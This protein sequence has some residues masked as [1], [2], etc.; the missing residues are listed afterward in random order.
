M[1]RAY[2]SDAVIDGEGKPVVGAAVALLRANDF[3][4][5]PTSDP[6]S[7]FYVATTY[8]GAGGEFSF[9]HLLPDD[10]HVMVTDQGVTAFRYFV[11]AFA[12]EMVPS[13]SRGG[14]NLIPRTLSRLLAGEDVVIQA[15]G[16]G[17]T[18]GYDSTGTVAGSWVH[19]LGVLIG[20]ELAPTAE[21]VRYDPGAYGTLTDGPIAA[22]SSPAVIQSGSGGQT[23]QIVNSSV[24]N[25]TVQRV[26]RRAAANLLEP[27]VAP[28]D[29]CLI[30]L[31]LDDSWT[32]DGQRFVDP[33][34]FCRG[35]RALVDLLKA[36]YSQAEIAL[37]TPAC[38]N[39]PAAGNGGSIVAG[40]YTLEQYAMGVRRVAVD[41]GCALVDVSQMFADRFDPSDP[42][43]ATND[44]YGD[45]L[46]AGSHIYPTDA[47]H[48]AMAE[49]VFKLF[50]WPGLAAGRPMRIQSGATVP[51]HRTAEICRVPSTSPAIGYGGGHWSSYA[52]GVLAGL[53]VSGGSL[54]RS[55]IAGD[56]LT[57]KERMTDVALLTR[58][59]ADCGMVSVAIDGGAPV[60]VD[61][62]RPLPSDI[63][64]TTA[65]GAVY[66]GEL[67]WLARG[68]TDAVH[69][70][71][72]TVLGTHDVAA[73]DSYVYVDGIHYTRFAVATRRVEAMT[74]ANARVAYG[75][76]SISVAAASTGMTT[77]TFPSP[78][79]NNAVPAVVAMTADNNW[80]CSVQSASTSSADIHIQHR[81][82]SN[83]TAT[84]TGT[85]IAIG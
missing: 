11:N 50:G 18:L 54:Q 78:F 44:G 73:T 28:V 38:S 15:V 30:Q 82:G 23:I 65:D 71:V 62:F 20:A 3:S 83:T 9:D 16:S 66:P 51:S 6:G 49:E 22:Y 69:T 37:I 24:K 74:D 27:A 14:R 80:Y 8:S 60:T 43:I 17:I 46:S 40:A 70:V 48:Q 57:F 31:G 55:H 5:P 58:R 63:S 4:S 33:E 10:Y 75:A 85:W 59:G 52:P 56:T 67:V 84:V 39:Q 35:L 29:L 79:L 25:D 47:G 68:L 45:W 12:V 21:I 1:S 19:R 41:S 81:D 53:Y 64:D 77:V 42:D 36:Q 32:L 72:V 13:L 76:F 2:I 34:S 7:S 26:M 61:L